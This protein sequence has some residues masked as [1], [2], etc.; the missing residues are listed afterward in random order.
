MNASIEFYDERRDIIIPGDVNAA[1]KFSVDHFLSLAKRNIDQKGLFTV[2]LSGGSTPKAIYKALSENPD[3]KKIDWQKVLCFF[4]DERAV[5]P[6]DPESNYHMAMEGGLKNLPIPKE[7]IFRMK[8]ESNIE[9]NAIKYE[10]TVIEH[11]KHFDLI[12]LG[13]G[14]DGHTASL[15]PETHGLKAPGR[16]VIANYIPKKKIWRMSLTFE[17]INEAKD[18]AIYVM[19][20][21][22]APMVKK[23]LEGPNEPNIYPIQEVGTTEHKALWVL[24]TAAASLLQ[25]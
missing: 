10:R 5:P 3:S 22:K 23:V 21:S 1:V 13:M 2:A 4:S 16:L 17:C 18:I 24:D 25:L 7:N 19:G 14:E 9:E 11:M 20:A 12:M 8:A 6:N 15:F